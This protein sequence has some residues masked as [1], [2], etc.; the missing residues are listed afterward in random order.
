MRA[1]IGDEEWVFETGESFEVPVELPTKWG[2]GDR[3]G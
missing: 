2:P 3:R 1:I